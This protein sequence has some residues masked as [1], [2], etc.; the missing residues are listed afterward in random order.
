[1]MENHSQK[2]EV[3]LI[4]KFQLM[5]Y[6]IAKLLSCVWLFVTLWTVAHETPLSVGFP[7]QELVA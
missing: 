5:C 1:M 2:Y 3:D 4:F 7:R 6:T